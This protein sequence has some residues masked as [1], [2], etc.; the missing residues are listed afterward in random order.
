MEDDRKPGVIAKSGINS[1]VTNT[2]STVFLTETPHLEKGR[3]IG[4]ETKDIC[5]H[6]S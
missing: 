6:N 3:E 5:Y 2:I 1:F 4:Q